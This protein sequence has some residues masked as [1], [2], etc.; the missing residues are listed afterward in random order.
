MARKADGESDPA[1]VEKAVLGY[2]RTM[3]LSLVSNDER[4]CIIVGCADCSAASVC[5]LSCFQLLLALSGAQRTES[6]SGLS[7]AF[8]QSVIGC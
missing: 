6:A 2:M 1:E 3:C 8:C 5:V 4:H 7:L